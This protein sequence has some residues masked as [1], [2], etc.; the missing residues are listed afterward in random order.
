MSQAIRD[1]IRRAE[2]TEK[3]WD[4]EHEKNS[5]KM[6][7]LCLDLRGFYL[8]AGQFLGTRR[9]FMPLQFCVSYPP[10]PLLSC[11]HHDRLSTTL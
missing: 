11:Q 1:P 10:T 8:K 7:Q 5:D 9:D 6:L 4:E 3:W 2:M